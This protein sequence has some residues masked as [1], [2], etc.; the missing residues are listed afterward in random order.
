MKH[1]EQPELYADFLSTEETMTELTL[2][3]SDTGVEVGGE[4]E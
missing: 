2:G 1:Y 3:G 4:E